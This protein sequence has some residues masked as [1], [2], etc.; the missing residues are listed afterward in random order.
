ME[1]PHLC[2]RTV[3]NQGLQNEISQL[4]SQMQGLQ[5]GSP[6]YEYDQLNLAY[7]KRELE[8]RQQNPNLDPTTQD[9]AQA[10][11]QI[12]N[13]DPILQA[14]HSALTSLTYAY[15]YECTSWGIPMDS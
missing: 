7:E 11:G 3:S 10:L 12:M 6:E 2:Y 13:Q 8:I 15:P 14:I 1:L 5:P 9:G 4:E